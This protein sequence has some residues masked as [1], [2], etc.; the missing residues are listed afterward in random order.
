MT[1]NEFTNENEEEI[2]FTFDKEEI[3]KLLV[4]QLD[5]HS[6]AELTYFLKSLLKTNVIG[7]DVVSTD[8]VNHH[9]SSLES[10]L[11]DEGIYEEAEIKAKA[12][13][14]DFKTKAIVKDFK[15]SYETIKTSLIYLLSDS[16]EAPLSFYAKSVQDFY[17][18]GRNLVLRVINDLIKQ[19]LIVKKG[20]GK[21]CSYTTVN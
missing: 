3:K 17:K 15:H 5:N 14:E 11:V 16:K 12:I 1:K 4:L 9:G 8:V 6:L 7:T 20:S 10:F 2:E 13:V 18:V 21:Y 19:G